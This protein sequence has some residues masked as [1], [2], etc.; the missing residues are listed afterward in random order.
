M[1]RRQFLEIAGR[2][3]TGLGIA[4]PL[5]EP[6]ALA[7]FRLADQPESGAYNKDGQ[8]A[9]TLASLLDGDWLIATDP[10]NAG[11]DQKWF[12]T[13]RPDARTTAVPSIIQETFPTY[14]GV[15]WYWRKFDAP[16]HAYK[17][18][19]YLLR[20]NAVDYVADV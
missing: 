10:G 13:P 20:F 11:R 12:L 8:A 15:V 9:Q 18:G 19:R 7:A 3:G 6:E 16:A 17:A 1:Q 4:G 2:V 14:H 5:M